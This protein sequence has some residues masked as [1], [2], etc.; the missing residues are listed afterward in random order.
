MPE[1]AI[2]DLIRTPSDRGKPGGQLS[3]VHPTDLLATAIRQLVRRNDI[4]GALIDD[5]IA[6]CV[7]QTGEPSLNVARSAALAAGL[8]SRYP[9]PRSTGTVGPASKPP[10]SRHR[11]C[12]RAR[13]TW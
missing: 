1:A 6:G 10:T 3:G 13:T 8:Q 9:V 4:D 12:W 7:S 11:V 5:G 2:V